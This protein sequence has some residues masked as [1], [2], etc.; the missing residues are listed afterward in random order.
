MEK[1]RLFILGARSESF[2]PPGIWQQ[3]SFLFPSAN[4]HVYFIGPQV[5]MPAN[6]PTP[7]DEFDQV[8]ERHGQKLW[9]PPSPPPLHLHPKTRDVSEYYGA[10]AYT[11]PFSH[12]VSFTGIRAVYQDVHELFGPFDPYTDVF[13]NFSPGFGMPSPTSP[14]LLQIA[15]PSEW[16]P[17]LPQVLSTKCMMF[18]TGFSPADIER[19]IRSLDGVEGVS[20]EFDFILTPG[21]NPFGS[22]KWEVNDFDPRVII[23]PNWGIWGIRGKRRDIQDNYVFTL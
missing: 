2:L 16:G 5:S 1:I 14:E 4:F 10:P 11:T 7:E 19:D 15:S 18:V 6:V 8:I 23:K 3:M 20:G 17:V 9:R 22:E 21:E 13:F 12:M